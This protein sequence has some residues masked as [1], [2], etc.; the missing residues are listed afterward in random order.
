MERLTRF[1][2]LGPTRDDLP[3]GM[4]LHPVEQHVV[5][6]LVDDKV[7]TIVRIVHSRMDA[8]PTSPEDPA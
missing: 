6:Y 2:D 7:V 5:Y 8:P 4:H 1:P 3:P